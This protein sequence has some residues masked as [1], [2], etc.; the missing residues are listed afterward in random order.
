MPSRPLIHP[1]HGATI[2]DPSCCV[3]LRDHETLRS[4]LEARKVEKSESR[5]IRRAR[6]A[7]I[8]E[9]P[10]NCTTLSSDHLA[11]CG[12]LT[13]EEFSE[14]EIPDYAD[15]RRPALRLSDAPSDDDGGAADAD[16]G[17]ALVRR[18]ARP[19][20]I[21]FLGRCVGRRIGGEGT[22]RELAPLLLL[23][24][25]VSQQQTPLQIVLNPS[26]LQEV[27]LFSYFVY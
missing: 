23:L 5:L 15:G 8:L 6:F 12:R 11:L 4:S 18:S 2:K 27:W 20:I 13:A 10:H 19:R 17:P 16:S 14:E 9:G 7:S 22:V 3:A 21:Q 25:F 26:Q 24:S 1:T